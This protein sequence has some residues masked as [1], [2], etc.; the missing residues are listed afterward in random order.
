MITQTLDYSDGDTELEAYVAFEA[1]DTQKPLVLIAHDW[2]GRREYATQAAERIALMGYVGL[3]LDMY[4]KGVFG[5]DGDVDGNA[6]LM[7]PFAE[8]RG[9]L[10]HDKRWSTFKHVDCRVGRV[11]VVRRFGERLSKQNMRR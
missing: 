2:T 6:A 4:G 8:D 11:S 7:G 5:A 1:A 3:A 9:L 10:R